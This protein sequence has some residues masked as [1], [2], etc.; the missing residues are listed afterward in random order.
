[1][2]CMRMLS[3]HWRHPLHLLSF[4][5]LYMASSKKKFP[6]HIVVFLAPAVIIYTLF[7]IYPLIDS[8]RLGF[9]GV[10]PAAPQEEIFVGFDNY[11][12]LLTHEQ[13]APRLAGAI[14]N[15]F[16]FFAVHMLVQNPVGLLLA[17]LLS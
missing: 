14:K 11:E 12:R 2:H 6:T 16:L 5:D 9:Y 1:V 3:D 4:E 13:W 10:D 15:N 17:V 8:L 7:M